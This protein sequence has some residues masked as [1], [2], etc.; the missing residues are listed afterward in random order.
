MTEWNTNSPPVKN[1]E[2]V[3]DR[4]WETFPP[5]WHSIRDHIRQVV[6]E[7]FDISVEQFHILRHIRK[8]ITSMSD[9]ASAKHISRPAISQSVEALVG[10]GLVTRRHSSADRRYVDLE[11]TQNGQDL[12][13]EVFRQ[14]RQWMAEKMS[15]LNPAE[16]ENITHAL[17]HLK[18]AFDQP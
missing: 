5:T 3:I 13:D 1:L 8:G 4:F 17:E 18:Q 12:L 11:L 15:A 2:Y 14:N 7:S 9:L 6:T 10:K 16:L